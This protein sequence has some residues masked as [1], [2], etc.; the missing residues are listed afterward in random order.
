MTLEEMNAKRIELG[1]SYKALA[2]Q[3]GMP[4]STVQKIFGGSTRAPRRESLLKLQAALFAEADPHPLTYPACSSPAAEASFAEAAPAYGLSQPQKK[5][6]DFTLDD[7]YALPDDQRV[8]LIDGVFYDM[9]A[10][11]SPHQIIGGNIYAQLL[12][13]RNAR[14][15]RCLPM[16]SPVDVQLDRDNKT[17]VQPDVLIVCDRS[18]IIRRCVYGAPDLVIEVLSPSTRRKD[19][20]LKMSKYSTA[21]VREYWMIDPDRRQVIVYDLE[22]MA[23]PVIYGFSDPIPVGIWGGECRIDL[24]EVS[25][26]LDELFPDGCEEG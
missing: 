25:E 1:L 13:F 10:P 18:K 23:I 26:L 17:M 3:A 15:G 19:M 2:Q 9:S 24:T 14:K 8:E 21:G 4:L 12:N 7:Y 6:G 22:H 20:I 5:P 11:S 16:V